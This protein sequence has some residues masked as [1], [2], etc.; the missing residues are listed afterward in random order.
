MSKQVSAVDLGLLTFSLLMRPHVVGELDTPEKY[1][2]FMTDLA[3]LICEHCG[4][5]VL[6]QA[7]RPDGS[8]WMIGIHGN[9]SLPEDG[10]VWKDIDP[11]G[12][13]FVTDGPVKE[14]CYEHGHWYLR[15]DDGALFIVPDDRHGLAETYGP[16][17]ETLDKLNDIY[18]SLEQR[19]KQ[20]DWFDKVDT[21]IVQ[22]YAVLTFIPEYLRR[23]DPISG[24][25]TA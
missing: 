4:G 5:E 20:P 3:K 16:D 7:T 22:T 11:E 19:Y 2:A 15:E 24:W 6:Y 14:P 10:G 13:L 1:Q 9:D 18:R 23:F 17:D 21:H 25:Y 8:N 12:E